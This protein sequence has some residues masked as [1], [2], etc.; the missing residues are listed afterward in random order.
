[1][2]A[3][4]SSSDLIALFRK[5]RDELAAIAR[6]IRHQYFRMAHAGD[7][8]TFGDVEGETLYVLV[9]EFRP[10]LLF[11]ISPNAGYSTNYLLAAL[12]KNAH[13]MLHSFELETTMRGLPTEQL[14]RGNQ[15][16]EWD[17]SRLTLHLGDARETTPKIAGTVDFALIDSCHEAWFAEWYT[18]EIFPRLAG[19]T[20]VQDIVFHDRLEPSGE[21]AFLWPYLQERRVPLVS[22]GAVER[23]L[24][25]LGVR[26]G[27]AER[28]PLECNSLLL[29]FPLT[30][31]AEESTPFRPAG[32]VEDVLA[33]S[34]A[35]LGAGSPDDAGR[36]EIDRLLN[37]ASSRLLENPHRN[38]RHRLAWQVAEGFQQIGDVD[39]AARHLQRALAFAVQGDLQQR[40]KALREFIAYGRMRR[41]WRLWLTARLLTLLNS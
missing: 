28:R 30:A 39:E 4:L 9:R 25:Q 2:T 20:V 31:A 26:E 27:F 13:G 18:R 11:E 1:M 34:R 17:Q 24:A 41:L 32:S 21:A 33:A 37:V 19:H 12:T 38:N 40:R 35:Q 6:P 23:E 5:Y 7:G 16:P 15:A 8:A 29:H 22:I 10:T 36:L 14:I 3:P